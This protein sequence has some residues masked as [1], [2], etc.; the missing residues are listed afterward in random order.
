MKNQKEVYSKSI[1]EFA[2]IIEPS[3][4]EQK[5]TDNQFAE[6]VGFGKHNFL[7]FL[8]LRFSGS[9]RN[10]KSEYLNKSIPV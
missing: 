10:F 3:K 1:V 4:Q 9:L 5:E 7:F 6:I 2:E 8:F